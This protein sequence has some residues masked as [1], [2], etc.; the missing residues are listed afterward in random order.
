M[1]NTNAKLRRQAIIL[2][3]LPDLVIAIKEDGTITFCSAQV[4][5]V[6]RH[7]V[8]DLIGANIDEV[9][10]PSSRVDLASLVEKLVLAEK[11]AFEGLRKGGDESGRSSNSGNIFEPAVVSEQS[12][13]FPLSVVKV[14]SHNREGGRNSALDCSRN[15]AADTGMLRVGTQ[16]SLTITNQSNSD[17]SLNRVGNSIS[18][19]SGANDARTQRGNGVSDLDSSSSS[20]PKNLTNANE[21]L[22]RNVRFHNEQLKIK[23]TKKTSLSH[24]DD[25]TGDS[26]TANNADARLSSLMMVGL[27][28]VKEMAALGKN[29]SARERLEALED[30]SSSS[31][32]DS[33]LAG[34]EDRQ[35][36]R[37]RQETSASDDSGYRES[38]ESDPSRED[39][40]S[41]TSDASNGRPRP[42]AP[43][44]NIC[45]IRADLS[46]IWC[47]VTSSIRTRSINEE[48]FDMSTVA[49]STS[50][51]KKCQ[52]SEVNSDDQTSTNCSTED[53]I[54]E[55]LLCLRPIQD[56]TEK[57]SVDL[58]FIPKSKKYSQSVSTTHRFTEDTYTR[59]NKIDEK[60]QEFDESNYDEDGNTRKRPT[61]KNE[62]SFDESMTDA[63]KKQQI[64]RKDDEAEKTVVESLIMMSSN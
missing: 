22:N 29:K 25:V 24:K 44:C 51:K 45:M 3:L 63:M 4:E 46:T 50:S 8:D 15:E 59:N 41:S 39:S 1:T 2:S 23:D 27:E 20:E 60:K 61:P 14:K 56:G 18:T 35:K 11:A 37:K 58:R 40:A 5:R 28:G 9:L 12:D 47:E 64:E 54:K 52:Y 7:K 53:Q 38:G 57:V 62:E 43:T 17:N 32:T 55:L 31:S 10:M 48:Q 34:V 26:V 30:N 16:S 49:T 33:L 36:K 21:A 6:L 42:L 13:S 19:A